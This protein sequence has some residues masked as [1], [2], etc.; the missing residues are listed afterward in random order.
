MILFR[1]LNR[2]QGHLMT[3]N[4]SLSLMKLIGSFSFNLFHLQLGKNLLQ[5]HI[6]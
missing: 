2:S 5:S 3:F 4:F 6:T 1:K